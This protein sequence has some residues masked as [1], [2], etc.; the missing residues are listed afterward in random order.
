MNTTIRAIYTDLGGTLRVI[1][2]D[3]AYILEAEQTIASLVGTDME[4]HEFRVLLDRRYD[5]YRKWALKY[6]REAPEAELWTRWLAFDYPF[7]HIEQNAGKL[8]YA[9]RQVKGERVVVERG[10]EVI[11]AL[12]ARGYT[13]GIISDLIGCAEIPEWLEQDGL[14]PYFTAVELSSV[15]CY[16]KPAPEIYLRAIEKTGISAAE[17]AFVGDN[18]NRDIVGAKN[19]G[20]GLTIGVEYDGMPRLKITEENKPDI[21]I[22]RY[23]DLLD[24][25]PACPGVNVSNARL[26]P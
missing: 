2:A 26:L 15:C 3:P 16:R 13:L 23:A 10:V 4:P 21:V 14:T 19:V 11:H 6:M 1:R 9:Y 17:S 12:H 5:E 8:T 7:S 20:F 25:F 18:L 22:R 24:L